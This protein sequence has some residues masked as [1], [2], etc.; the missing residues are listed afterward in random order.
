MEKTENLEKKELTSDELELVE[1][2]VL[3]A[4]FHAKDK[5]LIKAKAKLIF[6]FVS[7]LIDEGFSRDEAIQIASGMPI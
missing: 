4:E 7:S 2:Q 3:V 6:R 5:R 1:T